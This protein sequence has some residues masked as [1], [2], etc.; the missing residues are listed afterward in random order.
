MKKQDNIVKKLYNKVK[1][2]QWNKILKVTILCMIFMVLSEALFEIPVVANF[3]GEDLLENKSGWIVYAI[4]W[5][6]MFAQVTIIPIPALPIIIACSGINGLVAKDSSLAGLFSIETLLFLLLITSATV[7]GCILSYWIGRLLGKPAVKWI[8]GST[9]GYETWVRKLNSP[10]GKWTYASTVLF[11]IF[12]DDLLCLVAGSAKINFM[13][14][15]IV[16][17]VCKFVGFY[18]M[19]IFMRLPGLEIFFNSDPNA[20]PIALILYSIILITAIVIQIYVNHKIKIT[21]PKDI[22][23]E[24]VKEQIVKKLN[25]LKIETRELLIDYNLDKKF[26]TYLASKIIIHKYYTVDNSNYKEKIRIIIECKVSNYNQIVFDKIY[27]L[28]EKY[29]TLLNDLKLWKITEN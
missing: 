11:P 21:Q 27:N 14:Y 15:T 19:L 20:F 29:E 12:P 16:N 9:K 2:E 1:I 18:C 8:T 7:L 6:V 10:I 28:N 3:F 26:R 4:I 22:K 17:T 13:F 23:L 24:V 25:K 5:L